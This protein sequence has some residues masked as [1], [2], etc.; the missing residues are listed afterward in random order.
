MERTSYIWWADNDVSFIHEKHAKFDLF[1]VLAH[2]INS[3]LYSDTV[4]SF[5]LSQPVL[6]AYLTEK[7]H[8]PFP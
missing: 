5:Q 8:I 6:A 1:I 3:P 4:L 2:W 7:Q